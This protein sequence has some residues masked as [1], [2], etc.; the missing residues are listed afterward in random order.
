[1]SF[2]LYGLG[3]IVILPFTLTIRL[4]A[5]LFT[6]LVQLTK[7]AAILCAEFAVGAV[8]VLILLGLIVAVLF[9][10]FYMVSAVMDGLW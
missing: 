8:A 2:L 3:R 7:H 10:L 1:M 5:W 9:G 6:A 4:V